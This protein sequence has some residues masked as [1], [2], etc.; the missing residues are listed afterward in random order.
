MRANVVK[1]YSSVM[2]FFIQLKAVFADFR[3]QS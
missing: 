1:L 3:S 2:K